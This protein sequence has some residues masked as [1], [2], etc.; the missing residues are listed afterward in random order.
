MLHVV[1]TNSSVIVGPI[2]VIVLNNIKV[3]TE[4]LITKKADFANRPQSTTR[5]YICYKHVYILQYIFSSIYSDLTIF[6]NL[7]KNTVKPS[8]SQTPRYYVELAMDTC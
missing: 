8:H 6:A 4:A 2:R 5:K 1:C 3:V 7:N